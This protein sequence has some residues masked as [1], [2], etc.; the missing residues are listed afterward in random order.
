MYTQHALVS[1]GEIKMAKDECIRNSHLDKLF[2]LHSLVSE[3]DRVFL[4]AVIS[5]FGLI[6]SVI[7]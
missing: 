4:V 1:T 7:E 5:I 6:V 3:C 2:Q